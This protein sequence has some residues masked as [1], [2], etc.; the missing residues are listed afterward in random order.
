[1]V[2]IKK[3][4]AAWFAPNGPYNPGNHLLSPRR[5][6]IGRTSLASEFGMGS[7]VSSYVKSP[8]VRE[9]AIKLLISDEKNSG[10]DQL[11]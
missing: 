8:G 6:I 1:M 10:Y 9:T 3:V 5:T 11:T 4:R 2:C 7:G